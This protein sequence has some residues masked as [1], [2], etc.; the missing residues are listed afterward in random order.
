M[1]LRISYRRERL[2]VDFLG[3]GYGRAGDDGPFGVS[4]LSLDA[5]ASAVNDDQRDCQSRKQDNQSGQVSIF[6]EHEFPSEQD[7]D[8][9][10]LPESQPMIEVYYLGGIFESQGTTWWGWFVTSKLDVAF[11]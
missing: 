5:T 10:E 11:L 9:E 6:N 1:S 4:N 2:I 3:D 7:Q 8:F